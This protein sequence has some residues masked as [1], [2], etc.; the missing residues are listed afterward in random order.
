[1]HTLEELRDFFQND[2]FAM[3]AGAEIVEVAPGY[4]LCKM[5]LRPGHCNSRGTPM[6]GAIF[7][8][9]DFA[10]AV[11]ANGE[12]VDTH[13]VSLHADITFLGTAKGKCLY[14]AA[15]RVKHG[16]ST[17]LYT[18]EV[19]DELGTQVAVLSMN[20]FTVPAK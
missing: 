18:V 13:V 8:L 16:R 12:A 1:M 3:E 11:A 5:E 17:T 19:S 4:A 15:H 9:A 7:T 20:G 2:R 6:G 14:A 10:S